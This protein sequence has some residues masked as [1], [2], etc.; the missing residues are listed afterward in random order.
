D[1]L[2][3]R[4]ARH[5]D[6][7]NPRLLVVDRAG[8]DEREILVVLGDGADVMQRLL[9]GLAGEDLPDRAPAHQATIP[10]P[11]MV[12]RASSRIILRVHTG[13]QTT[14]MRRS[15]TSGSCRSRSRM[16]SWMKSI[17]GQP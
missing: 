6:H 2:P 4:A 3:D 12:S 7:V 1:G 17:A 8:A 13:S 5:D 16:S 15:C 14:S 11:R 9:V 10:R